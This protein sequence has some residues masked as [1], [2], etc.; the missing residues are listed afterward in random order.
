MKKE[1]IIL[2]ILIVLLATLTLLYSQFNLSR[3]SVIRI[4][5]NMESFNSGPIMIAYEADLFDKHNLKVELVLLKSGREVQQ[6]L[7]T[8]E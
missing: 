3:D 8:V 5:Y 2:W 7:A 1:L 6:A 4:G